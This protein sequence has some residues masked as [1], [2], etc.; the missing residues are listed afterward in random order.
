MLIVFGVVIVLPSYILAYCRNESEN[1]ENADIAYDTFL[2][3]LA[4]ILLIFSF[5]MFTYRS[6]LR[7]VMGKQHLHF[8]H[9]IIIVSFVG[10]IGYQSLIVFSC[11][12]DG[13]YFFMVQKFFFNARI[14]FTNCLY[15]SIQ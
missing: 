6:Y 11:I 10:S 15:T 1:T 7:A 3:S 4:I 5:H 12:Q 2:S 13:K 14:V 8:H 9:K